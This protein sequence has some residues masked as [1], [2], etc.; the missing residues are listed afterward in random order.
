M[1]LLTGIT[2]CLA[3]CGSDD[4][5]TGAQETEQ[6]IGFFSNRIE[7]IGT[8]ALIT[9][10]NLKN[11]AIG[12]YGYKKKTDNT[13]HFLVFDNTKLTY[14]SYW[15]YAPQK[16]WDRTRSY[17]FLAYMP[18]GSNTEFVY[19]S[20][21]SKYT[22][23]LL[24][25][26]IPQWQKIDDSETDYLVAYSTN[27]AEEY[28]TT[29]HG[30][31]NLQFSHIYAQL[32]I[33]VVKTMS[34]GTTEHKITGMRL[35][36]DAAD[37]PTTQTCTYQYDA[38]TAGNCGVSSTR[39]LASSFTFLDNGSAADDVTV[40]AEATPLA[41]YLVAPFTTAN[42]L[43][44]Y[45]DYTVTE[46]S[47]ITTHNDVPVAIEIKE[48]KSNY[49]YTYVLRF[50]TGKPVTLSVVEVKQWEQVEVTDEV[51]NW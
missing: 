49:K 18:H 44:L 39:T 37:I 30:T 47:N 6:A 22:D 10:D 24:F 36:S 2:F 12:V 4:T 14:T 1:C 43:K 46:G 42:N 26:D 9:D 8:R 29:H 35:V 38:K 16:Y 5:E 21:T 40:L 11:Q 15:Y 3:A 31:V 20:G 33:S 25:K 48:F 51:Y 27:S 50:E 34:A 45:L 13:D 7:E 17:S 19:N 41:H 28:L 23:Q 32:L